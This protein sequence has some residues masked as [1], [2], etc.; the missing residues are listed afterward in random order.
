MLE[1]SSSS[2][3]NMSFPSLSFALT[4]LA[5]APGAAEMRWLMQVMLSLVAKV[6]KWLGLGKKPDRV[7]Y[8]MG[9]P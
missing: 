8:G 2:A 6:R 7:P 9:A 1:Q 4:A 5:I 3:A